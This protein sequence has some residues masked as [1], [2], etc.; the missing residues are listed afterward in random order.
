MEKVFMDAQLNP[1]FG[2]TQPAY[3]T[4]SR[5]TWFAMGKGGKLG[6][7]KRKKAEGFMR[8]V[9]GANLSRL[10]DY[11]YRSIDTR[12]ARLR[13]LQK[14]CGVTLS[15]AQRIIDGTTGATLDTLE[16]LALALH[17]SVY[18]LVAPD[19]D[20]QNPPIIQGAT[21]AERRL[22]AQWRR[23]ARRQ[24]EKTEHDT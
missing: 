2:F 3:G 22:Y 13:A 7:T 15:S 18:Q 14:D 11:Q 9:V 6:Q 24:E 8:A 16:Q 17:V 20:P 21:E 4:V 12:T 23:L 5:G 10:I 1:I 19:I